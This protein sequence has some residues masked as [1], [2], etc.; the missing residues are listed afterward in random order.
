MSDYQVVEILDRCVGVNVNV[1]KFIS[2]STCKALFCFWG[3]T[4]Y[5]LTILNE[6]P[7]FKI[8]NP[9]ICLWNPRSICGYFLAHIE[10]H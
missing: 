8:L 3:G 2:A 4:K 9:S 6:A 10:C 7:S 1:M 5:V